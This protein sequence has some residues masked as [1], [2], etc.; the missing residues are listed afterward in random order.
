MR[1]IYL[2]LFI[3]FLNV[4]GFIDCLSAMKKDKEFFCSS[5]S[6]LEKSKLKKTGSFSAVFN[7]MKKDE[8]FQRQRSATLDLGNLSISDFSEIFIFQV[9]SAQTEEVQTT[10]EKIRKIYSNFLKLNE[11]EKLLF[12]DMLGGAFLSGLPLVIK[13]NKEKLNKEVRAYYENKK[14]D[15]PKD[16]EAYLSKVLNES[17]K[18]NLKNILSY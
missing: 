5:A 3:L 2:A 7:E 17:S 15:V 18:K 13:G 11:Q 10:E 1:K 12:D 9:S 8:H 14:R 6:S 16:V 4:V